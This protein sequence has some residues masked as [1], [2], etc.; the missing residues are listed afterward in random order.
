[1]LNLD[2]IKRLHFTGIGGISMSSLAKL[3]ILY[4][5]TITGSDLVY[6]DEIAILNQWGAHIS[7]GYDLELVRSADLLVYTQ[8][9]KDDN[10]ELTY[11][12]DHNIPHITRSKFLALISTGF[13]KTIAVAGTHGKTTVT[14]M[15]SHVLLQANTTFT[16]HL[17]GHLKGDLGNLLYKG[18]SFF[19]TEACEYERAFLDLKPDI[20]LL[21]DVEFDH[22]DSYPD[23][24]SVY[25]AFDRFII[26]IKNGGTLLINANSQYFLY[27]THLTGISSFPNSIRIL[28]YGDSPNMDYSVCNPALNSDACYSARLVSSESTLFAR[29]NIPGHYNLYNALACFSICKTLGIPNEII[30]AGIESFPG[31]KRRFQNIQTTNG[32][33]VFIDYA[34]HPTEI[35]AVLETAV[36]LRR[37]RVI[38][39]F[40]PHTY[41][42]TKSL[43]L[44]FVASF[45]DA[46]LVYIFKEFPAREVESDGL[47]A[48][49][50]Y[51]HVKE[52]G[53]KTFYFANLLNLAS[54]ISELLRPDDLLVI[55]GAGDIDM[56]AK[57]L[58]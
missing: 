45:S 24:N 54:H 49:S 43:L 27:K 51:E 35:R 41:S 25:Q 36:T 5:K 3:M 11:A 23:I 48:F 52:S 2:D 13:D 50:L 34:H 10:L 14:G 32:A 28:T 15:I 38:C 58:F 17:G 31:I 16:A 47:P 1:M 46:D 55:L 57:L 21:L 30:K 37:D 20:V 26:G 29:L 12:R 53:K 39:V 9:I 40:Q 7:I 56:L 19:L 33:S 8:A 18:H 4:Q 22:P 44:D 6:S 42:R